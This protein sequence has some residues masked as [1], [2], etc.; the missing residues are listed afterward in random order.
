M[1]YFPPDQQKVQVYRYLAIAPY[2]GPVTADEKKLALVMRKLKVEDY[3]ISAIKETCANC[4]GQFHAENE[5]DAAMI[6]EKKVPPTRT[7]FR[8]VK[9]SSMYEP[10]F[11][12]QEVTGTNCVATEAK[13][14]KTKVLVGK[15]TFLLD[16]STG[17]AWTLTEELITDGLQVQSLWREYL[18]HAH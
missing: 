15:E 10:S 16:P 6:K 9:C 18:N 5:R 13:V 14:G 1:E 7:F 12:I 4:H 8:C 2:T 17:L 3:F 11:S